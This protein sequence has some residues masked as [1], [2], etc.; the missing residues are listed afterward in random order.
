[1][2][3]MITCKPY[4]GK[5]LHHLLLPECKWYKIILSTGKELY[6]VHVTPKDVTPKSLANFEVV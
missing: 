3:S 1:V 4:H 6:E 5:V 2:R